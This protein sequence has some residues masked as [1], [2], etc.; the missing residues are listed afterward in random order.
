[1]VT[2]PHT[3]WPVWGRTGLDVAPSPDPR[4]ARDTGPRGRTGVGA[5]LGGLDTRP[6]G[7][8]RC[9]ACGGGRGLLPQAG[10]A[11]LARQPQRG[12][13]FTPD[14]PRRHRLPVQVTEDL[15]VQVTEGV[16]IPGPV[17]VSWSPDGATV[18]PVR[19]LPV[20]AAAL[21]RGSAAAGGISR[22][23]KPAGDGPAG[24]PAGHGPAGV[25]LR[26]AAR[27][28][29]AWPGRVARPVGAGYGRRDHRRPAGLADGLPPAR[30]RAVAR[31]AWCA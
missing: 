15:S 9:R 8:G 2:A 12:K 10:A 22:G 7:S 1:V 27:P 20:P 26:T 5:A 17:P 23:H 11:R 14:G 16:A 21:G 30:A 18:R 28:R 25:V 6:A 19:W 31:R 3:R 29:A 24:A 4:G 13:P